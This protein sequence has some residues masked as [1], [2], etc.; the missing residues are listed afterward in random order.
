MSKTLGVL[1]RELR[2]KVR[3]KLSDEE[4]WDEATLII[5]EELQDFSTGRVPVNEGSKAALQ[6]VEPRTQAADPWGGWGWG[7]GCSWG[8]QQGYDQ[9]QE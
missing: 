7:Q 2:S 1:P 9:G 4:D 6:N 5:M 8:Q 3:S